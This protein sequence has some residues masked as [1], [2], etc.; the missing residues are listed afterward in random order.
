MAK[1][2]KIPDFRKMY[3]EAKEAVI[4]ELRKSERKMQYEEYDLKA[5]RAVKDKETNTITFLPAREDSIERLKDQV[6]SIADDAPGTEEQAIR[7]I[8][9]RQLY[10]ALSHLPGEEKYLIEQLYFMDRSEREMAKEFHLSQKGINKRKAQI[11]KRLEELM[12]KF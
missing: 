6:Y 4:T 10:Q 5:E 11:I 7:N 3:P 2:N 1:P 12:K 9:Y 8:C